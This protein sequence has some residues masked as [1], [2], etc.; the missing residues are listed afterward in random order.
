MEIEDT[1][2]SKVNNVYAEYLKTINVKVLYINMAE[3]DFLNNPS[4]FEKLIQ[5]I[6]HPTTHS[7]NHL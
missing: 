5:F 1:Y 6:D 3:Y 2:L 4:D 7:I